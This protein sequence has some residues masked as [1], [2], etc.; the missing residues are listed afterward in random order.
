MTPD[1]LKMAE[2]PIDPTAPPL[3]KAGI[4]PWMS[5]PKFPEITPLNRVTL[6]D[7]IF[8]HGETVKE[9][10]RRGDRAGRQGSDQTR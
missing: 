2:D 8:G 9:T 7:I 4:Y 5:L 3:P 6:D 10:T 1:L